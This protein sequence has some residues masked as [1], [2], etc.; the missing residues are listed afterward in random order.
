MLKEISNLDKYVE[1]IK[2]KTE[3]IENLTEAELIRDVYLDLGKRFSFDLKF[4][5]GNSN[6]KKDIYAKSKSIKDLEKCMET[7]EGI[8]KSIAYILEYVLKKLN[9]DIR[10]EIMEEYNN[11]CPHVYNIVKSKQGEEYIIDLQQDL[12]NIQS[13]SRTSF[14]GIKGYD[15]K[16]AVFSRF[17]LEQ[18]DKKLGYIKPD[19]YYSDDYLYLLKSDMSAFSNFNEK[20]QFALENLEVNEMDNMNYYERKCHHEDLLEKIFTIKELRKIH[21]IDCYKE[22]ENGRE[23]KNC[24]AVDNPNGTDIYMFSVEENSYRKMDIEDFASEIKNGL[25]YKQAIPGLKK[26]LKKLDNENEL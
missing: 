23:Y 20:V 15:K 5:F 14:F 17:E 7:N 26:F 10:T 22:S 3:N 24:I 25:V 16:E 4:A 8:C 13:H 1:Y 18:M 9:V 19:N 6:T 2:K 21:L 11:R 12:E